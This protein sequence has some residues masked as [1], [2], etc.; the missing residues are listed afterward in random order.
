M[1]ASY[2]YA[3]AGY[4]TDSESASDGS[5]AN[6]SIITVSA[7][8]NPAAAIEEKVAAATANG[9]AV[10]LATLR[11]VKN[12]ASSSPKKETR[13]YKVLADGLEIGVVLF[14]SKSENADHISNSM[15]RKAALEDAGYVLKLLKEPKTP[16][17]K[18]GAPK[19]PRLSRHDKALNRVSAAAEAVEK[20]ATDLALLN[21]RFL[22][23]LT[24][25][26]GAKAELEASVPEPSDSAPKK[27]KKAPKKGKKAP[28]KGKAKKGKKVSTVSFEDEPDF[29]PPSGTESWTYTT[30]GGRTTD[31]KVMVDDDGAI[32]NIYSA[33]GE[34]F[35]PGSPADEMVAAHYKALNKK[36]V[37]A[38]DNE[39]GDES[40]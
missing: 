3:T 8:E 5:G 20:I 38:W 4:E 29:H 36:Y 7:V 33:V 1:S 30:K 27:A 11:A 31:Y 40:E 23:A 9:K 16:T 10:N 21:E 13:R 2:E 37:M 18:K 25:L 35:P 6:D 14:C 39:D 17:K 19:G 15:K 28:K 12:A 26:Q 34:V 22:A 32:T 24:E